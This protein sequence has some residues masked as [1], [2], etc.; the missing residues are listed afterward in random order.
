M[1]E[2]SSAVK[3]DPGFLPAANNLAWLLS[4]QPEE[5]LRDGKRAVELAE[6]ICMVPANRTASSLDT[7]GVAYAE[8]GRFDD[9]IKVVQEA[10]GLSK[11]PEEIK[12]LKDRL[13]LFQSGKPYRD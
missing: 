6:S 1:A 8:A 3:L 7:L 9:A 2:Y 11:N 13:S 4:T 12:G 5:S 10:I